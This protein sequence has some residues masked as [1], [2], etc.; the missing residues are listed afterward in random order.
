MTWHLVKLCVGAENLNALAQWQQKEKNR[1][2]K[3]THV[4]RMTPRR[5]I[6]K[7]SLYWVIKGMIAARQQI[8]ALEQ[9]TD[10]ADIKRC[11]IM[12]DD[13]LVAT[14]PFPRRPFQ[15]WRY[16]AHEDAPAD[17]PKNLDGDDALPPHM[18]EE[19]IRLGLL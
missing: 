13:K 9:F 7:G 2:G 14:R 1:I 3:I 17:L 5:D 19:L 6:S 18:R 10:D 15:G 4:T 11:R 8:I 16:L 12:L